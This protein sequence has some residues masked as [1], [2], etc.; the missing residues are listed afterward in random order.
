M[1]LMIVK[2]Y[3][4]FIRVNKR[5]YLLLF[6]LPVQYT[7]GIIYTPVSLMAIYYFSLEKGSLKKLLTHNYLQNIAKYSFDFYMIHELFLIYFR[8]FWIEVNCS[9]LL[10]ILLIS[11]PAFIFSG[12]FAYILRNIRSNK[13]FLKY[14]KFK[15]IE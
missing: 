12:L 4:E 1:S 13:L 8:K 11:I 6:I 9:Y 7:R 15:S 5:Q 2:W 10:K 3:I 14:T